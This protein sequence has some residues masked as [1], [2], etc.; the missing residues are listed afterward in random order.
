MKL[1]EG[2]CDEPPV[3]EFTSTPKRSHSNRIKVK[4]LGHIP[5][6]SP[7]VPRSDYAAIV[8]LSDLFDWTNHDIGSLWGIRPVSVRTIIRRWKCQ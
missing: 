5:G 6:G 3:G 1:A 7:P 8:L 2:Y 4:P